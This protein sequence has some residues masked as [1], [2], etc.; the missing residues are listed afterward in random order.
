MRGQVFQPFFIILVQAGF[1]VIDEDRRGN[2]HR[3]NQ[4]KAFL[5]STFLQAFLYL[6]SNIYKPS[7]SGEVEE[8]FFSIRIS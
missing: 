1:V 3:T 5:N 6:R 4:S 2:M 8:K 7:P